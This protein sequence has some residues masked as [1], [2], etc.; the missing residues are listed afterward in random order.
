MHLA[1]NIPDKRIILSCMISG[2][3]PIE[4]NLPSEYGARERCDCCHK[5]PQPMKFS[6][7]R[8]ASQNVGFELSSGTS[9]TLKNRTMHWILSKYRKVLMYGSF[10]SSSA[11]LPKRMPSKAMMRGDYEQKRRVVSRGWRYRE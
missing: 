9:Q 4:S 7:G 2:M 11:V 10:R 5:H 3:L 6:S 1:S 8:V